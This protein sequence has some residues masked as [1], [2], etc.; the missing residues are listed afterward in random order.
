MTGDLLTY[1]F[2]GDVR[3]DLDPVYLTLRSTEPVT[4]VRLTSGGEAWIITRFDDMKALLSDPRLRRS[5]DPGDDRQQI[6]A[7]ANGARRNPAMLPISDP[8]EHTRLRRLVTKAFSVNGIETLRP[9][10]QQMCDTLLD[11]IEE[12]GPPADLLRGMSLPLTLDAIA[13]L[14][15][16]PTP[17]LERVREWV[18]VMVSTGDRTPEEIIEVKAQYGVYM[19]DIVDKRTADPGQDLISELIRVHDEGDRLDR[20]EL[21][22]M[23]MTLFVAG[24]KTTSYQITNFIY[25]LLTH[26]EQWAQ[27]RDDPGVLRRAV[28]ELMRW[29]PLGY[30]VLPLTAAED[31][32]IGGVTIKAG[33]AVI[34]PKYAA[35]RD[36]DVFP[37][38][39][40]LD[41]NRPVCPHL[42]FGHGA[43]FCLGAQLA[44]MELQVAVGTVVRRFPQL[45]LAVPPEELKWEVGAV[46]RGLKALPVTW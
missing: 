5:I 30:A 40:V 34:M 43:H 10:V 38:P 14:L 36:G 28:E 16:V 41:F 6:A 42:G 13:V 26:P 2:E 31:V 15:G 17:D 44:R 32:E 23:I 11:R 9:H 46:M 3:L 45:R 24:H 22:T 12:S 4:R 29:S 19:E 33:D 27:L 7:L 21:M 20:E 35:N 37:D 25:A 1:P 8:P 39:D 18:A